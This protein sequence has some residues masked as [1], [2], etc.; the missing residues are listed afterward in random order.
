MRVGS[1][2]TG[3]ALAAALVPLVASAEIRRNTG[4]LTPASYEKYVR[5][6]SERDSPVQQT[7]IKTKDGLYVAAAI[8]KPKG[9]GPFPVLIH[10]GAPPGQGMEPAV[11]Q[12][13]GEADASPAFQELLH[14]GFVL[15]V[16]DYRT[17]EINA[18]STFS[19]SRRPSAI[20][21]GLAIIEHVKS[22]P[23]V[24]ASRM[25]LWGGS[26]GANLVLHLISKTPTIRSAVLLSP[27][28]LWFLGMTVDASRP[29]TPGGLATL[30][31]AASKPDAEAMS[32]NIA[33]IKTP[34][35][36]FAG[37]ADPLFEMVTVLHDALD[38]A[39]KSVRLEVYEG[40]HDFLAGG[41]RF[42]SGGVDALQKS[43]Q[44]IKAQ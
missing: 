23:F 16:A 41:A 6:V 35:L 39:K 42:N 4:A 10:Y 30:V 36:I 28:P 20:D 26:L 2:R 44:F 18:V 34:I 12:S 22:L 38:A 27:A 8:R 25:H 43:L 9:A 11:S 17:G 7:Y 40:G 29:P 19:T 31:A 15:V 32:R 5:I 1:I 14:E 3:L 21:D 13:R 37:T 24:D 33:P